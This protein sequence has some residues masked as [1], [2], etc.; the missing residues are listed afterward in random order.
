MA[1]V[2]LYNIRDLNSKKQAK[3]A[4]SEIHQHRK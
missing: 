4:E 2:T 3:Y 1:D